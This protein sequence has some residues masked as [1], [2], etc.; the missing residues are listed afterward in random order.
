LNI[1]FV[2]YYDFTSNSAGHVFSMANILAEKHDV[3]VAVPKRKDTV[4]VLG[5]PQF[6]MFE[7]D[8]IQ[9]RALTFADGRGPE[10]VHAWTPREIVRTFCTYLRATAPFRQFIHL[11]DNEWHITARTLAVEQ[12]V[13]EGDSDDLDMLV[14][15]HLTHPNRSKEFLASAAGVTVIIDRLR[16]FVPKGVAT[17]EIWVSA[18]RDLFFPRPVDYAR[19]KSLG[20]TDEEL[21]FVYTG[22]VHATNAHE[23]RSIYLAVAILNREGVPARLIRAGRDDYPFLGEEDTWARQ[24]SV[25]LGYVAHREIPQVLAMADLLVQPGRADAFND[26]RLPSKLPEFFAMGKPVILPRT[27][28]GLFVKHGEEAWVCDRADALSIVKA[29]RAIQSDVALKKRLSEGAHRFF[30]Q[31]LNWVHAAEKLEAFYARTAG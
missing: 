15:D 7:F 3:A 27:N 29:T 18:D 28:L 12:Q 4:S 11:E 30:D 16:E 20:I 25:E 9:S 1:L 5:K 19:R 10:I 26:Y 14:P 24:H 22:N 23:V 6:K 2:L 21:V 8:E 17:E 13:L 31:R